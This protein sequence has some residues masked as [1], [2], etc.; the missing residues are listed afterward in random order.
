MKNNVLEWYLP[1]GEAAEAFGP[2]NQEE[3]LE[4][5]NAGELNFDSFIW[6]AHFH[7]YKWMRIFELAEF[8]HLL[9]VYPTKSPLPKI[10]SKGMSSQI[11]KFKFRSNKAGEYGR[12]NEYRRYPRAP[13]ESEVILHDQKSYVKSKSVD[14]SEKGLSILIDEDHVFNKGD[15]ISVTLINSPVG[16]TFSA[17]ATV[18]RLLEKPFKGY[19]LYFLMVK[20]QLK[21]KIAQYV[22]EQLGAVEVAAEDAA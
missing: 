5:F 12:E 10:V 8:S 4:K 17:K 6:G 3:I 16:E 11:K 22:I 18:I 15:E 14:I 13:M 19:G 20:P 2:F 1:A 7:E 9:S 21:R